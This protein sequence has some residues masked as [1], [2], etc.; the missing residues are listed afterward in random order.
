MKVHKFL[1]IMIETGYLINKHSLNSALRKFYSIKY[2]SVKMKRIKTNRQL[3]K[4]EKEHKTKR[5]KILIT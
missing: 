5:E 2:L 4:Q 1:K 3:K